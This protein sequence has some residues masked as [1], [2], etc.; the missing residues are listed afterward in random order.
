VPD[1]T[2]TPLKLPQDHQTV[3]PG[4]GSN[5]GKLQ[6]LVKGKFSTFWGVPTHRI[7]H[8]LA[9][10]LKHGESLAVTKNVSG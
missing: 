6:Q 2:A 8:G 1:A 4:P 10:H 3:L 9:R 5:N 7:E